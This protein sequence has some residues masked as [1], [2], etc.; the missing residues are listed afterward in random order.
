M[1]KP[2]GIPVH[3]SGNEK[4]GQKRFLINAVVLF[5]ACLLILFRG[6]LG[7]AQIVVSVILVAIAIFQLIL[8][9]KLR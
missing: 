1:K 7:A 5:A 8:F 3:K 4:A 6:G 2:V 9:F